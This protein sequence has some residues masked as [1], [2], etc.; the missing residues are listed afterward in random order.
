[1]LNAIAIK[2]LVLATSLLG[3]VALPACDTDAD[4]GMNAR[5]SFEVDVDDETLELLLSAGGVDPLEDDFRIHAPLL[6]GG[7]GLG[8]PNEWCPYGDDPS[9]FE[10]IC[11]Y[12]T[13]ALG[14]IVCVDIAC[15]PDEKNTV[16]TGGQ[17]GVPGP[18]GLGNPVADDNE[19]A[20]PAQV[21]CADGEHVAGDVWNQNGDVC[22]C[23]DDGAVSC[24]DPIAH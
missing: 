2:T 21:L 9:A 15:D 4:D 5:Q 8:S 11:G 23:D 1:M 7:D 12:C 16:A 10:D 24:E 14:S 19:L 6:S 3:L 22:G 18:L 17:N 13:C 20:E